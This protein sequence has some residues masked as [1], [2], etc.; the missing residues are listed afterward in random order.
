MSS[1]TIEVEHDAVAIQGRRRTFTV[2]GAR[3]ATGRRGLVLVFHGS[4]QSAE[5]HRRFSEDALAPLAAEGAAVVV[6]L[7]GYRGNWNDARR[8]SSFPA[9]RRGVDDVAFAR[10]VVER[11]AATHGIDPDHVVTVGYSNGGQMVLRLLHEAPELVAGAVVVAATMPVPEDF[12]AGEPGAPARPTPIALVH[13]TA[14]R[15][16]P[17]AGGRMR[18]WAEMLFRVGGRALSAPETAS[19][20]ARRNGIEAEA[21]RSTV[22]R[23]PGSDGRTS[24]IRTLHA[25][26]GRPSVTFYEVRGGGHTLPGPTAA[27]RLIGRSAS[28]ITLL[29]LTAQALT[30]AAPS[31]PTVSPPA[32]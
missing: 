17:F 20:L 11:V 14:D 1:N 23:R 19:Y 7:D 2:L 30:D 27:P 29:D 9:R 16:V 5:A 24:V 32:P 13:G 21:Q 28:D 18:R 10:A 3:R 22:P 26:E 8:Q 6:Y 15:I 12:L 4:R 25:Q 31:R